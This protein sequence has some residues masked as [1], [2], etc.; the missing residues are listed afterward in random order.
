MIE[1]SHEWPQSP[2]L[3]KHGEL[4]SYQVRIERRPLVFLN[5]ILKNSGF[6]IQCV[7]GQFFFP[8]YWI[9][10]FIKVL[11]VATWNRIDNLLLVTYLP[12]ITIYLHYAYIFYWLFIY[13]CVKHFHFKNAEPSMFFFFITHLFFCSLPQV[14]EMV[15]L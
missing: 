9:F 8:S 6:L 2:V 15:I 10:P 7:G 3:P 11:I 4:Q 1:I 13:W 12:V 14:K 5:T